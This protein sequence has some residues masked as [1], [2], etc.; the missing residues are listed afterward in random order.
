MDANPNRTALL[1]SEFTRIASTLR[2]VQDVKS[3]I[4]AWQGFISDCDK[5]LTPS[6]GEQDTSDR[7]SIL[8]LRQDASDR[9][10]FFTQILE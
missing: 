7:A 5:A 1:E 8:N 2:C 4:A 6:T 9:C 3:R 10:E